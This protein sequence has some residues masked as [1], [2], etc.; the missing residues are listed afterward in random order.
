ML[1][2]F[3]LNSRK[4][5]ENIEEQTTFERF[6]GPPT[7]CNELRKLGYTL[8][9]FYLVNGVNDRHQIEIIYCQFKSP[10]AGFNLGK[11]KY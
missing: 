3:S 7:S 2:I 10:H 5:S 8:N 9:G 6:Y 4:D 1:T 11:L